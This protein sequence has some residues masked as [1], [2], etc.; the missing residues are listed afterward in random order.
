ITL[1]LGQEREHHYA[2]RP[3]TLCP[4]TRPE[5]ALHLNCKLYLAEQ[6]RQV[7]AVNTLETCSI[8]EEKQRT[9][10]WIARWD[11]VI[12]EYTQADGSNYRPD[13][14]LMRDGIIIGAIEVFVTHAVEDEKI[15]WYIANK[16][17]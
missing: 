9:H 13:I 5:T 12:V 8:C 3:G 15:K 6:L 4:T 14:A 16:I 11:E 1:K 10:G 17:P 7:R 2:H